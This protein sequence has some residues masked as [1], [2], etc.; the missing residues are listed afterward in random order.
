TPNLDRLAARSVRYANCFSVAGVCAP[1]RSGLITGMY[2]SSLGSQHMRCKTTLPPSVNCFPAY[3]RAAGYY[4]SNNAK[5]DYNFA[6]PKD[7]WDESSGK[8]HW[9]NRRPGQPFFSAFHPDVTHESRIRAEPENFARLTQRLTAAQRHDP[10]K[11]TVPPWHPDTPLVRRDWANYHDLI[12][13]ADYQVADLLAQLQ[14]DGLA[15]DTIVFFFSDHGAGLPRAKQWIF[16][17]GLQ[18]PLIVHFPEK[19]RHLA[20]ATPG[21]AVE[22]LVSLVD[23]APSVLS[24]AGEKIPAHLQGV[25]FLGEQAGAPRQY[26]FGIRDRMDERVDMLRTVRD[27]RF[28]YHRNYLPHLPFAQ[29]IEYM[30]LLPTMKELRRLSAAGQL[31]GAAA[32]FMA[33]TKAAE[34]LYDLQSDPHETRNL[35][36]MAEHEPVLKRMR[37]AHLKWERD[38]R[39]LS[40]LPEADMRAR[41]EGSSPYEIARRTEAFPLE[42]LLQTAELTRHGVEALPQMIEA[43][44]DNHSAVRYWGASAL[45]ALGAK[46]QPAAEALA[47]LLTDPSPNVR[48]VAAHALCNLGR[49]REAV[50]VLAELLTDKSEWVRVAAV[51]VLDLIDEKAR[52]A[53][54]ALRNATRDESRF[55][56]DTAGR[57]LAELTP[58]AAPGPLLPVGVARVDITPDGPIRLSGY[59]GRR[60]ESEGI[61]QKISAKALAFGTDEQGPSVLITAELVGVPGWLT[62]QLAERLAKKTK[63]DRAHLA[64]CATHT[65]TGP[66]VKGV[67]P[68]IF[69]E[70][71]PPEHQARIDRYSEQLLDKLEQL[72]LDALAKRQ[73]ARL[74]WDQGSVSFAVNRRALKDGKWTGFGVNPG[75][76]TDHSLPLLRVTDAEGKV[77]AIFTSYACHCTT[78]ASDFNQIHGDWAGASQAA[79]ERNYPGAVAMIAIGCGADANPE[80]RGKFANLAPHVREIVNEADRLLPQPMQPVRATPQCR[81][82]RIELP[83]DKLP[84]RAEWEQRAKQRDRRGFYARVVLD[85]LD[86]GQAPPTTLSYP[87]QTWSFGDDLAMVFLAGEVVVDYSLRLKRELDGERLWVNAYANDATCYIASRRVIAE[88]GYEVDGSMDSYDRPTPFAP[89]VEDLIVNTVKAMLPAIAIKQANK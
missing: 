32:H 37:E 12:T 58:A 3:L 54:A 43:L 30:D 39:D 87:V 75:G 76:P 34:E 82:Q 63:V 62:D 81:F 69:G 15:D 2:P 60:A 33:P 88:G 85:R 42:R 21:T 66:C 45:T 64:V 49:E 17:A 80:P 16:E 44:K 18:V 89:A 57:A 78:L 52:P 77:L 46:A 19:W 35:V 61:A 24:L 1:S 83:F 74:A 10:A 59:A 38:T 27:E 65:H 53:L 23:F 48:I 40:L 26:V 4:C 41:S 8:A 5:Q 7:V 68:F 47:K 56:R 6:T 11:V 13:A 29:P 84:A 86:R 28:K 72:A 20:P 14:A 67:L 36:G 31:T 22:R 25:P 50:P 71:I 9:R 55:V 70:P 51:N 79:L 73:P